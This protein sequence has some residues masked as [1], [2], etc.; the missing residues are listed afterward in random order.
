MSSLTSEAELKKLLA[1]AA[2]DDRKIG[3]VCD[4]LDKFLR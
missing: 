1:V 3:A 2:A 4:Q